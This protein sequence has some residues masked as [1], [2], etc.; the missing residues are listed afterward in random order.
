MKLVMRTT[1]VA[2]VNVVANIDIDD[3]ELEDIDDLG[4]EDELHLNVG[5]ADN[6]G[7]ADNRLQHKH[8]NQHSHFD[9]RNQNEE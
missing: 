9:G 6:K 2:H 8:D 4:Y 7:I 5:L 3:V 1:T